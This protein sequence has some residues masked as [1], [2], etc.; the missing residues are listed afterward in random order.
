M[1][2][3]KPSAL[4][5]SG[6]VTARSPYGIKLDDN[7]EWLNW[8]NLEYREK[9]WEADDVQKGDWVKIKRSG[10]FIKSI[11]LV[12]PPAQSGMVVGDGY[13]PDDAFE[14]IETQSVQGESI[15]NP[16][17]RER[18][19]EHQV[20]L[21]CAVELAIGMAGPPPEG[22]RVGPLNADFVVDIY[23]RF[24]DALAE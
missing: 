9:P 4:E 3:V 18:S 23:R 11:A 7:E 14:G 1:P 17:N 21:K 20:A 16:I 22:Q 12:E 10:N 24:R 13:P 2:K 6:E 19:I 5:Y 8:S 15:R